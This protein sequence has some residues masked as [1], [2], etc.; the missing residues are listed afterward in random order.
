MIPEADDDDSQGQPLHDSPDAEV[1]LNAEVLLPQGEE[2]RLAK[3]I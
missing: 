1:L 2:L 3:V